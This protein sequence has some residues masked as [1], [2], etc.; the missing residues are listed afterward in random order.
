[1][2]QR[3][4]AQEMGMYPMVASLTIVLAASTTVVLGL[5]MT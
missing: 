4:Q 3:P 1:M 5:E 2:E